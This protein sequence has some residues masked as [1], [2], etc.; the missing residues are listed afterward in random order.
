MQVFYYFGLKNAVKHLFAD[1]EWRELRAQ[2]RSLSGFY[3]SKYAAQLDIKTDNDSLCIRRAL[4]AMQSKF[5]DQARTRK[6]S[7]TPIC[8]STLLLLLP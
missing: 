8:P 5:C 2:D 7:V 3:A 4:P 1:P 6:D